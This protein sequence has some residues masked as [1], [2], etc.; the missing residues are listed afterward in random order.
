MDFD[1]MFKI[2]ITGDSGS[3]K[4]SLM[5]RFC[6]N[7]FNPRSV[8]TIGM[9][10]NLKTVKYGNKLVKLKIWDTSG[11]ERFKCITDSYYHGSDGV[12]VV[13]D[14]AASNAH[15]D[16]EDW[17]FRAEKKCQKAV[18]VLVVANKIDK[19]PSQSVEI[20]SFSRPYIGTS[21]KTG[22]NVKEAFTKIIEM[23][24]EAKATQMSIPRSP[25]SPMVTIAAEKK[26]AQSK[27]FACF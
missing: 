2:I 12:L 18:P 21:A 25:I 17:V 7:F 27:C 13:F 1:Y 11:Q 20:Y 6:K 15:Y 4:S 5:S 22:E 10:L 8:E 24:L 3:G 14:T 16:V 19:L 23:C 9:D 26:E